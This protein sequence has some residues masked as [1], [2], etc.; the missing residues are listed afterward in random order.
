MIHYIALGQGEAR[1]ERPVCFDH[2]LAYEFEKTTG[3]LYLKELEAL[4]VEITAAGAAH[5]TDD[6][7]E[8]MKHISVVRYIDFMY[9]ALRMGA[10]K[11]RLPIDFDEYDVNDWLMGDPEAVGQLTNW[12][13]EDNYS[14]PQVSD[15]APDP[16][17]LRKKKKPQATTGTAST[18]KPA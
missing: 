17:E 9:S 11:Q 5:G 1:R 4:L 15:D 18:G 6:A 13:F 10:R 7:G 3:K 12:L 8:A 2:S 14:P 16:D